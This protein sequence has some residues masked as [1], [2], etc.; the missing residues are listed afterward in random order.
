LTF[1]EEEHNQA[2][3]GK[4]KKLLIRIHRAVQ[5]S[6]REGKRTLGSTLLEEYER[7]SRRKC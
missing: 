2:W 7:C 4:M 5:E 6:K 1:V 3:A